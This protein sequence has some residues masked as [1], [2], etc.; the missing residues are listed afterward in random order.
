MLG[1]LRLIR[2]FA[3][4]SYVSF[5]RVDDPWSGELMSATLLFWGRQGWGLGIRLPFLGC[6]IPSRLCL[7]SGV[8]PPWVPIPGVLYLVEL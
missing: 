6:R 7:G 8:T 2:D 1:V 5:D 3:E 4:A